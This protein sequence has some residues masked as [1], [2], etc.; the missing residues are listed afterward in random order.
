M[1]LTV[2]IFPIPQ[3]DLPL[4]SYIRTAARNPAD[5]RVLQDIDGF[6]DGYLRQAS[7]VEKLDNRQCVN[8]VP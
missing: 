3:Q 4:F 8:R 1:A 7:D 2:P 5:P 6:R